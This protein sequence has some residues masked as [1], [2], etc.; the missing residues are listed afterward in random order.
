MNLDAA[1]LTGILQALCQVTLQI[2]ILIKQQVRKI[3]DFR[4]RATCMK[5]AMT[6]CKLRF[7][8]ITKRLI[9]RHFLQA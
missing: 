5:A 6:A 9:F 2:K 3:M 7:L 4:N 8:D 1:A